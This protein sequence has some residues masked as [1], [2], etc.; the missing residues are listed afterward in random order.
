MFLSIIAHHKKNW[1]VK[2]DFIRPGRTVSKHFHAVL[3]AII[4]LHKT[5]LVRQSPIGD[6]CTDGIWR[7]F[8]GCLGALD[9]TLIDVQVGEEAKD[10]YRTRKGHVAV[11]IL[12]LC[13]P[14]MQFMYVLS[15]W[16]GSAADSRVL[17]DALNRSNSLRVPTGNY[18]LC[19]NGYSNAEGF[20]T[21]YRGNLESC[22]VTHSHQFMNPMDEEGRAINADVARQKTKDSQD[23]PGL[24]WKCDNEF[25]T[26]YLAQLETF[27]LRAIPNCDLKAEPHITS[28]IQV[29][30]RQYP[31]IVGMMSKSGFGWDESTCMVTIENNDKDVWDNYVKRE[32]FGK[33][34]AVGDKANDT[35]GAGEIR[36][37]RNKTTDNCYI[38]TA[39]W[40]LDIG[41]IGVEE[42]PPLSFH[43]ND[44]PTVNSSSATKHTNS[45]LRKRKCD[46]PL[47]ELPQLMNLITK[48]CESADT[49]MEKMARVLQGEFG[50]PD[51][52]AFVMNDVR[53]L[54]SF[55]V[56]EQLAVAEHLFNQP[57]SMELLF[58]LSGEYSDKWVRLILAGRI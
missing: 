52:R 36:Q 51:R 37:E 48:F 6:D 32:I 7:F 34:R 45:S 54:D 26:G 22:N 9:G 27:M 57:K 55:D 43:M 8:K 19:D 53:Q 49:R 13:N 12:G 58:S 33:D 31:S 40:N 23:V 14:N 35:D 25:R 15:G 18:Y 56:N 28:R 17:R 21:S 38:P 3:D 11:N 29:W 42:E 50:D 46:D 20:L 2:H 1:V 24:G 10:K 5:F 44:D 16:E 4:L 30:K 41:F 47:A 39:E